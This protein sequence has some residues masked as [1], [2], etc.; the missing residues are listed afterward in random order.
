MKKITIDGEVFVRESDLKESFGEYVIVRCDRSGVFFAR[1]ESRIGRE[2]VLRDARK[3]WFWAGAATLAQLAI[4]GTSRPEECKFPAP[5]D[6]I[7]VL[8][9]IEILET[10]QKARDSIMGVQVWKA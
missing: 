8:D 9:V 7:T 3:I 1:I 5:V 4:D 2:A 10:T 6:K